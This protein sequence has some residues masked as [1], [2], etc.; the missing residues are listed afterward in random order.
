MSRTEHKFACATRGS[1]SDAGRPEHPQWFRNLLADPDVTVEVGAETYPA[2]AR[3][4]E[5]DERKRIW[6]A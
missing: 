5:G 6:N 3:V 1:Q 4:A 2:R